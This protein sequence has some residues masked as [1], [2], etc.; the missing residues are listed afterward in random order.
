M[1]SPL[2]RAAAFAALSLP[3]AAQTPA[4]QSF[5]LV[6][7]TVHVGDGSPPI[8]D[9]TVIVTGDHITAVGPR[10]ST[11]VPAGCR[12]IDC[13]GKFVT[14]GLIDTHVHYSQTGWADG[15]PDARDVRAELPYEASMAENAAHPERFHLA[16]LHAGVTA[17]FDC[18]GYPWTRALGASTEHSPWAP[19]V[20][21]A[22]PLLATYDPKVLTLPDQVQFVF[23]RDAAQARAFVRSHAAFGSAAIKVWLIP[24]PERPLEQLAPV[25]L[26]AGDEAKKLG[27]PLIVHATELEAA[28]VAVRAGASLLVHSVENAEVD[29]AFVQAAKTAGTRYC[30]TLTVRDGY[31]QLY[32]AKLGDEVKSQL[33][34]VHPSIAE[35]V[36]RTEDAD[37]KKRAAAR[38]LEG[39]RK[40][41]ALQGSIMAKNLMRLHAAGVPV[42]LG[43]DAGNPLTLH[44]PSIFVELEA[45]QAAG[46]PARDVLVA[47]TSN[48]AAALGRAN[49]LG[50]VA[51]GCIAD[52]L[53]LAQDPAADVRAFRSIV[54]VC[55]AGQLHE[56]A[57]L[58]E[59]LLAA[60]PTV[61]HRVL[62]QG[63]GV[64]AV[65]DAAGAIEW[66][67]PW[68][69]VH[70]LHRLDNGHL[71][72]QQGVAKVVEIDPA[73]KQVV[74]SYD[75]ATQNGN[76]GK[77]VEVHALQPLAD[78]RVLIAESGPARLLEIERDGTVRAT[79]P[80]TVKHPD[81]HRDTRLARKLANGHY[82]VCHEGDGAVREYDAD[83]AVVWDFDVP[84]FG[85]EPKTGH[86][87]EAFG[88][89]AF[90]AVRLA[91]GN[92]LVA[93]GNGHSVLLVDPALAIVWQLQQDEL[94]GIRLAWVTTLEV[95][96][97][98]HYVLG[99][100]HAGAGQPVLIEIEPR[101]KRVVW[102]LDAFDRF[103]NDVSNSLLLDVDAR[104]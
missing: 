14:P 104:R 72:T 70:D 65:L 88:N 17:V 39:M 2:V 56:R 6:G 18:G 99:N 12:P 102:R 10:A 87:P 63:N 53:V 15:R 34:D 76:A 45:M 86:G 26:A 41:L 91:D 37:G 81:A 62:L 89:Q 44:G 33:A 31:L 11:P 36:W 43:T 74:W 60:G 25:V 35:R 27:L 50:R 57:T 103:G 9:A 90:G 59:R 85:R 38:S 4:N 61:Q 8:A 98:G 47:A 96:P 71:L 67:M 77:R 94:P 69:G 78:G 101:S 75:A 7:G 64:L 95:L 66:Q 97:N 79:I 84:L 92:T 40:R 46:L 28:R 52:L 3:L 100:C 82:L 93:T 22:G 55:R 5:A 16:F 49:D 51:P 80:L 48:A 30:P 32:A 19:H 24:T 20:V 73:T 54:Q 23:P 58:H 83:G 1:H 13:T 29:D 42:V 21:A 68:D